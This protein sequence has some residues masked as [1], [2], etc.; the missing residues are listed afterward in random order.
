[1]KVTLD[2]GARSDLDDI[3]AWIAKRNEIAA[4]EMIAR[5]GMGALT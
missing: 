1:M 5:I 3:H 4:R 2:R